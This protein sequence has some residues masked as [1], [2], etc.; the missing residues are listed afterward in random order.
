MQKSNLKYFLY[1]INHYFI[2]I[3][4]Y[5]KK[6]YILFFSKLILISHFLGITIRF[7]MFFLLTF[8]AHFF[9]ANWTSPIFTFRLTIPS[10]FTMRTFSVTKINT[11]R[12]FSN[13]I[14]LLISNQM[15]N[16]SI[17]KALIT[18]PLCTISLKNTRDFFIRDVS[19]FFII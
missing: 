10:K 19:F 1:L 5:W 6:S 7:F 15:F 13:F 8:T 9:L 3:K 16:N 12:I 14:I 4:N 2:L 17:C 11:C 18:F